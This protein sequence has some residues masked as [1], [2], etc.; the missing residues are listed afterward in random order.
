M[1]IKYHETVQELTDMVY[2]QARS[3]ETMHQRIEEYQ[4]EI[5]RLQNALK[6]LGKKD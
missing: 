2:E 4:N 5:E 3:I 1:K 6:D